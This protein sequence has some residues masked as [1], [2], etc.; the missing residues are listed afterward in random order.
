MKNTDYAYAV[1]NIRAKEN[2]LLSKSF[3]ESLISARTYDDAVRLLTDKGFS[4]FEKPLSE[5][6]GIYMSEQKRA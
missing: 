2:S 6:L 5:A 3:T 1:S 4:Y